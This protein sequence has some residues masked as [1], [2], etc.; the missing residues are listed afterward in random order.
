MNEH[1]Y[2]ICVDPYDRLHWWQRVLKG[3]GIFY[4]DRPKA[5]MATLKWGEQGVE[6]VFHNRIREKK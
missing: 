1:K 5:Y 6:V 4:R 3:T 2:W